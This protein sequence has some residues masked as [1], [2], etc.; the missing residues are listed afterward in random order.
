MISEQQDGQRATKGKKVLLNQILLSSKSRVVKV[1]AISKDLSLAS[2]NLAC[3]QSLKL[4]YTQLYY[5]T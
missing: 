3:N 5:P 4:Y 2:I 1:L